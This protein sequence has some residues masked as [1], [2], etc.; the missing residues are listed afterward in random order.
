[1]F[2]GYRPQWF[3]LLLAACLEAV[4][5]GEIDRLIVT[6][7]PRHGKSE[8]VSVRFPAWYLGRNPDKRV[9]ATSYAAHL[10]RRFSGQARNQLLDE[11]WPFP[12]ELSLDTQ[13]KESWDLAGRRGGYISA[14]VGGPITGQGA[15]L[16]LIDD[17]V[18][19]AQEAESEAFRDAVWE[20]YTSTAYT[21]LEEG[22]AIV[23]VQTRWHADDLAGRL[24]KQ[25]EED[26]DADQ[27]VVL[28]LPAIAEA[29]EPW[30]RK[31][32]EALWPA[33]YD[34]SKLQRI[35]KA[36]GSRFFDALYQQRPS[37]AE[38]T[39][40][41]R[42]WWRHWTAMPDR[43]DQV[44]LSWD[45]AFKDTKGSDFVVGQVWGTKGADAYLLDQ[46]RG[47]LDFPATVKAFEE[48]AKKWPQART[49]LV[50]DKANGSAVIDTLKHQIPGLVPIEPEGGKQARAAAVSWYV[51]AGN[52]YLPDPKLPGYGWVN[53][54]VDEASQ[55]PLGSHDD[56]V[57]ACT[58]ALNRIA[59]RPRAVSVA[60]VG[61]ASVNRWR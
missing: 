16:L 21:R 51:E 12:V 40:L 50:E 42:A 1:M 13:S 33:K 56:Q 59:N 28:N 26:P 14:G 20:W 58:Q 9:I 4:E 55:F 3:H 47:R 43:F 31:T 15:H 49:K 29:D 39:I 41:K 32:G 61:M 57:D 60:P 17:P 37:A 27:W 48:Q 53:E 45:M 25:A 46:T 52:V 44:L 38:G 5:R 8:Q 18:K 34:L 19:N 2:P 30:G 6:M 22:G 36:I 23:V 35:K 24:I 7:P 11:R 54:F 10:A